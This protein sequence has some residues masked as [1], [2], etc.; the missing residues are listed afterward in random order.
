MKLI[1]ELLILSYYQ[2]SA[3]MG[4]LVG[5]VIWSRQI[6]FAVMFAFIMY[7]A[8]WQMSRRAQKW[9]KIEFENWDPEE[10]ERKKRE[11]LEWKSSVRRANKR[12]DFR[13]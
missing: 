5:E 3:S 2:A 13:N 10:E 6:G 1:S 9:E 8:V 12:K 11:A 7:W 4:Y